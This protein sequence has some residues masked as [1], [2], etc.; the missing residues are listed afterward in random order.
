MGSYVN[1]FPIKSF[2]DEIRNQ[3]TTVDPDC[4]YNRPSSVSPDCDIDDT[5]LIPDVRNL[6]LEVVGY[7]N[8]ENQALLYLPF[9]DIE[10][11]SRL[12]RE[13]LLYENLTK[14]Y[15]KN[16]NIYRNLPVSYTHLTLPTNR[17]V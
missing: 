15:V 7:L 4:D 13:N 14:E 16:P 9:V 1:N 10:C 11:L 5:K 8:R 3:D 2:F 6:E 17:E 12:S